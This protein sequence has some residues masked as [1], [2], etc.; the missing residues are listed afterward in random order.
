MVKY[1]KILA[2]HQPFT[3]MTVEASYMIALLLFQLVAYVVKNMFRKVK[4][5]SL[6][7]SKVCKKTTQYICI[8]QVCPT[9]LILGPYLAGT[10]QIVPSF[11]AIV[12]QFK[13]IVHKRASH[14]L[15]LL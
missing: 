4:G 8:G 3:N 14:L 7:V 6:I 5:L 9:F 10:T 15:F 13:T 12:Q 1:L 11:N 2:C